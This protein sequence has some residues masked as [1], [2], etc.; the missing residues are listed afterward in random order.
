[1]IFFL[2]FLFVVSD[3]VFGDCEQGETDYSLNHF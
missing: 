2:M 3:F 1:M